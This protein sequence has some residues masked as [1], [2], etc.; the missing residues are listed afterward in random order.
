MPYLLDTTLLIDH[1]AA[2]PAAV[3]LVRRLFE[4]TGELFTCDAV[5]AEACS[6]GSDEE[7]AAIAIDDPGAGIRRD[8]S[9]R[10]AMGRRGAAP[11]RADQPADPRRRRSSPASRGRWAP[12]S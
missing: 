4:E 7:L 6:R 9:G 3:A 8:A 10:G 1:A 12:R 2:R 11:R 5:V